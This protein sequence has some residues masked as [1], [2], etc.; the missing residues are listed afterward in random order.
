MPISGRR[1]KPPGQAVN[2]N[3]RVYGWTEVENTPNRRGRRNGQPSPSWVKRKWDTWRR[4]PHARLW[5]DADWEFA[6]DTIQLV[7]RSADDGGAPV[8]LPKTVKDVGHIATA[9]R[10]RADGHRGRDIAKYLGVSSATL[11]RYLTE[12]SSRPEFFK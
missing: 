8:A 1:P 12:R 7:A 11:Y 3:P 9:R 4:M 10:M 6:F 2:R 5:I